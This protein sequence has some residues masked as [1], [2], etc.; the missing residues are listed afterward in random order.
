LLPFENR[1]GFRPGD[2]GLQ[3]NRSRRGHRPLTILECMDE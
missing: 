2:L 1:L 3:V